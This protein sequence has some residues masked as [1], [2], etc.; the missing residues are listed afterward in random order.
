M[1][2]AAGRIGWSLLFLLSTSS[3]A[4]GA[5]ICSIVAK[6]DAA[7]LLGQAVTGV[8][9]GKPEKDDD[10]GATLTYCTYRAGNAAL[11]VAVL[12]FSSPSEARSKTT[13][14]MAAQRLEGTATVVEEPGLGDRAYWA[15]SNEGPAAGYTVLKGARV[16]A[17]SLGGPGVGSPGKYKAGLRKT[18]ADALGRR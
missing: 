5:D 10:T 6:G 9:P 7:S 4:R 12:E 1:A 13:K 2:K 14:E 17:I 8:N 18:A 3:L 15:V 16:L 11:V